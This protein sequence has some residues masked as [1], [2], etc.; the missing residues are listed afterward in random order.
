MYMSQHFQTSKLFGNHKQK[1]VLMTKVNWKT[2]T[3]NS[4][5]HALQ[6]TKKHGID[7]RQMSVERLGDHLAE[8]PDLL[9]KW[10]GSGKWPVNKVFAF[11]NICGNPFVTK[12]L[13][14]SH[15]YLLVKAPTGNKA[16]N[17]DIADL[18]TFMVQVTSL[19][20]KSYDRQASIDETVGTIKCLMEDLAFHQCNIQELD[21][22]SLGFE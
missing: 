9:Y 14:H 2:A 22:P 12:Y 5:R 3:P 13:A 10:M 11:E 6:L 21:Q 18:Q 16:N 19:L 15:G 7:K 4:I 20:L 1:A 17:K 8:S